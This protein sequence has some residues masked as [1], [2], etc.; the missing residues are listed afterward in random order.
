[1]LLIRTAA[2]ANIFQ[3][4]RE[5][6]RG[7]D[8][9]GKFAVT[10]YEEVETLAEMVARVMRFYSAELNLDEQPALGRIIPCLSEHL[11]STQSTSNKHA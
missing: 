3:D 5:W 1:M 8:M 6:Q 7:S 4:N 10:G 9:E 2:Q 11:P